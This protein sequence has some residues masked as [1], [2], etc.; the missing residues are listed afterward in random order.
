MKIQE[1]Q[2]WNT[3]NVRSLNDK[4]LLYELVIFIFKLYRM[5]YLLLY[6]T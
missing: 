3:E 5:G 2:I 6:C 4:D 1:Q